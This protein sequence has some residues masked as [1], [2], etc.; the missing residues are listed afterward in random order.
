MTKRCKSVLLALPMIGV[1]LLSL[2][3]QA[4]AT[5]AVATGETITAKAGETVSFSVKLS[6]NPGLA[7]WMFY[8]T[9]NDDVLQYVPDSVEAGESFAGGALLEHAESGKLTV[10]WYNTKD[11]TGNGVALAV[12]FKVADDACPGDYTIGVNCSAPNT[13]N[14]EEQQVPIAT[15]DGMVTVEGTGKPGQSAPFGGGDKKVPEYDHGLTLD[16]NQV[17]LYPNGSKQLTVD[18]DTAAIEWHSSDESVVTVEDGK[19]KAV[20]PGGATVTATTP[21]GQK[22]SSCVVTVVEKHG[23]AGWIIAVAAA[24]AIALGVVFIIKHN[25]NGEEER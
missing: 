3:S 6:E 25:N 20:G 2:S 16:Y 4:M 7:A 21:D 5:D 22:Q 14:S 10:S 13:I 24:M 8:L 17:T 1:L 23:I 15:A 19:L 11:A 12:Q 18:E 9:W